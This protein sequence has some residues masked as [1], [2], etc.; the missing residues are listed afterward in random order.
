MKEDEK[1]PSGANKE[2][3]EEEE[4]EEVVTVMLGRCTPAAKSLPPTIVEEIEEMFLR[5]GFSWT[6][7]QKLVNDQGIDSPCTLESLPY[8]NIATS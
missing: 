1:S 8:K 7:A 2:E 6:V 5:L 3:E 4:E